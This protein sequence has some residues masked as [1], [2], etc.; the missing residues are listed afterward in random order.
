MPAT[1]KSSAR[2][3]RMSPTIDNRELD[4]PTEHGMTMP[5]KRVWQF[6]IV[7]WFWI[8]VVVATFFF[9]RNWDET[10]GPL[11]RQKL[12]SVVEARPN[13]RPAASMYVTIPAMGPAPVA[14][15]F[16]QPFQNPPGAGEQ[17]FSFFIGFSR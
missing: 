17:Q 8:V 10:W 9:G 5:K 7:T 1:V 4:S 15:D 12:A 11:L 13:S 14:I 3:P 2:L 16:A 6:R